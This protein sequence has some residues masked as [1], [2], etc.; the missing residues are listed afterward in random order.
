MRPLTS[1]ILLCATLVLG[2]WSFE[3]PAQADTI[4]VVGNW[5]PGLL[6]PQGTPLSVG[7]K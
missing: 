7:T 2:L 4:N 5:S 3:D 1:K 6:S